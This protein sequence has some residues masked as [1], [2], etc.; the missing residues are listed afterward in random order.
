[1][2]TREKQ[3]MTPVQSDYIKWLTN[4]LPGA[5]A[6][7]AAVRGVSGLGELVSSNLAQ[8]KR[9]PD[10]VMINIPYRANR[11]PPKPEEEEEGTGGTLPMSKLS[12]AEKRAIFGNWPDF[13]GANANTAADIPAAWPATGFGGIL[14]GAGGYKLMDMLMEKRKEQQRNEEIQSAREEYEKSLLG[15]F[16]PPPASKIKTVPLHEPTVTKAGCALDEKTVKC[17]LEKTASADS[18]LGQLAERLDK[19]A[20]KV[21]EKRA[22]MFADWVNPFN[23][24][25][26]EWKAKGMGGYA[27]LAPAL[28]LGSGLG[29]YNYMKQGD[30]DDAVADALRKQQ[31]ERWARRPPDVFAHLTPVDERGHPIRPGTPTWHQYFGQQQAKNKQLGHMLPSDEIQPKLASADDEIN[32]K[33]AAF[34]KE[35]LG[36]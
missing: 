12:S 6:A 8:P 4:F 26:D 31:Q 5:L 36:G 27:A 15:Q 14:A 32:T 21:V 16:K 1:M 22:D 20:E 33:A 3:G 24:I 18:R 19:L 9:P 23:W 29:V 35:F 30:P 28:A 7:G 17:L 25:P 11:P 2:S 13:W 10:P 34:V